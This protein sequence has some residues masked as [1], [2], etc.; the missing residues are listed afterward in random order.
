MDE[1]NHEQQR[2]RAQEQQRQTRM[3]EIL[4]QLHELAEPLAG[5]LDP[6]DTEDEEVL[7]HYDRVIDAL[8]NRLHRKN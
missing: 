6:N 4:D 8:E 1:E 5:V 3:A 7:E 2:R